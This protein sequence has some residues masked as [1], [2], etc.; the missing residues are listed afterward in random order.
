VETNDWDLFHRWLDGSRL[1]GVSLLEKYQRGWRRYL[2]KR[3]GDDCDDL[4]QQA[5][6][7]CIEGQRNFRIGGNFGSY[8]FGILKNQMSGQRRKRF[9][10]RQLIDALITVDHVTTRGEEDGALE[11]VELALANLPPELRE[12]LVM[13]F[14]TKVTRARVALALSVPS[15]TVASRER[16]AKAKLLEL[17]AAPARPTT[18]K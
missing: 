9:R 14:V 3:Y 5:M 1:A 2:R 13:R 12:V 18:K 16:R 7:A 10:E 15:G 11:A 17:L 4:L 8:V 6:L